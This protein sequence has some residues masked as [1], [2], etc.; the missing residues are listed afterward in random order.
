MKYLLIAFLLICFALRAEPYLVLKTSAGE[1]VAELYPTVAP[2]TVSQICRLVEAGLYDTT[3]F[4]RLERN[5]VLQ[6]A[7]VQGRALPLSVAQRALI[8]KIP[9]EFSHIKHQRGVLSMGREDHDINSAE[10]SFSILLAD[11]PHLDGKYTIFGKIID[12][13]KTLE[14]IESLPRNARHQ[15]EVPL[16]IIKAE[17]VIKSGR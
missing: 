16:E 3:P 14:R 9:G 1:L 5:F 8:Q 13:W 11:A 17:I 7:N 10:S 6:T 12:G 4:F 2:Q 15:P